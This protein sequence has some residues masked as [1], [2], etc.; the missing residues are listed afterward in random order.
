MVFLGEMLKQFQHDRDEV[1]VCVIPNLFRDLGLGSW[2]Q[3]FHL[4]HCT[5][6]VCAGVRASGRSRENE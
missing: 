2:C 5:D 1:F 6:K 3:Y 4:K